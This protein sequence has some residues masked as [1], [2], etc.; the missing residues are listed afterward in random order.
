VIANRRVAI[1]MI[2]GAKV[3][4]AVGHGHGSHVVSNAELRARGLRVL[5][6]TEGAHQVASRRRSADQVAIKEL[7][8][9]V[10]K[11]VPPSQTV[12]S[13]CCHDRNMC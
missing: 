1:L 4:P 7:Q 9:L 10:Q 2:R 12:M 6:V 13:R 8:I 5:Q 3:S 11:E